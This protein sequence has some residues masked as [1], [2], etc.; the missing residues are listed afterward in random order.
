[1]RSDGADVAGMP[2]LPR[3]DDYLKLR[4]ARSDPS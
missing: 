1:M 4:G 2:Y 3:A